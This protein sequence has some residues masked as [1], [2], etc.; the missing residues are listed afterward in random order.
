MKMLEDGLWSKFKFQKK[1]DHELFSEL[2]LI[3]ALKA[4][5]LSNSIEEY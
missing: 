1:I 5:K 4:K 3:T 2:L